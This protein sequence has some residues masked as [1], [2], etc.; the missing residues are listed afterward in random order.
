VLRN[1]AIKPPPTAEA[2]SPKTESRELAATRLIAVG[3]TRD[4]ADART[5]PYDFDKTSEPKASGKSTNTESK[6]TAI[7]AASDA[8]PKPVAAI[9]ARLARLSRSRAGPISGAMRANGTMVISR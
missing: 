8:R 5:I 3:V 7:S 4:V 1:P 6:L 2:P 9:A